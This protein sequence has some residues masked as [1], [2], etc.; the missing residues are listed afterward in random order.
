MTAPIPIDFS[1]AWKSGVRIVNT[2]MSL[3][4][5]LIIAVAIFVAFLILAS[6]AESMV[7]RFSLRRQHGGNLSLLLG[8]LAYRLVLV[9]GFLVALSDL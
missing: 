8:Q 3:L 9:L 6:T 2:A 7:R 4:P 5:N 1:N